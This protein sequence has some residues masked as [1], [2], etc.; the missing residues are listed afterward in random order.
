MPLN[1]SSQR[2]HRGPTPLLWLRLF[3]LA[4]SFVASIGINS[5]F[6]A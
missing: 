1:D 4:G 3:I 6:D 5:R 2:L